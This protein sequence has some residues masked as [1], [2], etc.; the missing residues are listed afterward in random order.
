MVG[1][2]PQTATRG[3]QIN[4]NI[5]AWKNAGACG[6]KCAPSA[7]SLYNSDSRLKL[8]RGTSLPRLYGHLFEWRA[9][10]QHDINL[11]AYT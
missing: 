5:G 1:G 3:I 11:I 7:R 10:Q 6:M 8:Q 4:H 9:A 2:L